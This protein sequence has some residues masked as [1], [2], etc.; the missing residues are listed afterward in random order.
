MTNTKEEWVKVG[1]ALG[2][3]PSG[4]PSVKKE[5][6]SNYLK[7]FENVIFFNF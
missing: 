4:V 1:T 7:F 5:K 6:S 3:V 2:M